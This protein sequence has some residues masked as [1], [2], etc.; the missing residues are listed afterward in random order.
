MPDITH[1]L[2]GI[3]KEK[4][5]TEMYLKTIYLLKEE[6]KEDPRPVNLVNELGLSKGSVSEMLKKLADEKLIEYESYGRIK[7]TEKG[8]EKAKNVVRKYLTIRKFL[9]DILKIDHDRVHDEACNLEHAFSDQSIAKLNILMRIF[10][11]RE[12]NS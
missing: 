2:H 9:E 6:K 10:E 3:Q 12:K 4:I 11:T 7:L 1:R 5:S 8:F